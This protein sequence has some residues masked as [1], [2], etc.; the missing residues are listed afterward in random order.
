MSVESDRALF[1][2]KVAALVRAT[3][4]AAA[5]LELTSPLGREAVSFAAYDEEDA[6][7]PAELLAALTAVLADE[8]WRTTP[9]PPDDGTVG[10]HAA[11]DG[12]GG[13]TFGVQTSVISF[14]GFSEAGA[15]AAVA[16]S[17]QGVGPAGADRGA[18]GGSGDAAGPGGQGSGAGDPRAAAVSAQIRAAITSAA[19]QAVHRR[20]SFDEDGV[21]IGG[22]DPDRAS[23]DEE[24]LDKAGTYL[25]A[26]GWQVSPDVRNDSGD[27]SAVIRK[28]GLASGRLHATNGGLTFIGRLTP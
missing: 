25:A 21:R 1:A 14:T 19:P 26:H 24:L 4:P 20:D 15:A 27:R 10:L 6:R 16:E 22:S 18:D 12:L 3:L 9:A 13:G 7:P 17:A 5:V 11:K 28:E 8:G 23:C 2:E